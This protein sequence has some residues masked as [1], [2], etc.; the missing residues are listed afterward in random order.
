MGL[1]S[2]QGYFSLGMTAEAWAAL[3][4]IDAAFSGC[5]EVLQ[6]RMG[7]LIEERRWDDAL[8][9]S[10]DMCQ[11]MPDEDA[12]FIHAA[13]CLHEL[14]RTC[15]AFDTLR[16]GP[17]SLAD[18]PVYHYNIACYQAVLGD[19]DNAS[20]S[21][22]RAIQMDSKLVSEALSDPDLAGIRDVIES[23]DA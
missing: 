23:L 7:F 22:C 14:G 17:A 9:L 2:A 10:L 3:E 8:Q 16:T 1:D 13:Y 15:D 18:N 6:L 12:G 4:T 21:V 19:T 11:S 20:R 5:I